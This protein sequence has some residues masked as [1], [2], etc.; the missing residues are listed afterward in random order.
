ML[1]YNIE[2]IALVNN[3]MDPIE[4]EARN[5]IEFRY[6]IQKTVSLNSKEQENRPYIQKILEE[7][8]KKN[9]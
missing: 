7:V 2:Q 4:Q 5:L 6:R 1:N 9:L 8:D 3:R